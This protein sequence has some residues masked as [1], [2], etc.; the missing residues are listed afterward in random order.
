MNAR[1]S[2]STAC[3]AVL[4]LLSGCSTFEGW[5]TG[6]GSADA[7]SKYSY[8]EQQLK[9]LTD[10]VAGLEQNNANLQRDLSDVQA[11][12]NQLQGSATGQASA[13]E[14]QQL[15]ERVQ[16][17]EAQREKDK[18]IILD[19]VAKEIA[20]MATSRASRSASSSAGSGSDIG[21]EHVVKQGDTL[22]SI[23]KTYGVSVTAI[24]KANNL[25]GDSI[26]I[27]QK[28]FIPKAK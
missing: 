2:R 21:Y 17:L 9:T 11:R 24:R 12:L 14:L 7:D 20:G 27:G 22:A 18:Q 10:R 25:S 4:A 19:Q 26:R 8:L 13:A 15:R 1:R 5:N 23:A 6:G 3:L 28:L 16:T